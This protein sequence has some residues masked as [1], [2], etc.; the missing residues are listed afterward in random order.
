MNQPVKKHLALI[1]DTFIPE[2]NG[3]A[4]TLGRLHSHFESMGWKVSVIRPRAVGEKRAPGLVEG[5]PIPM[6]PKLK[7]GIASPLRLYHH[8][9]NTKPDI[10]HIATEGPL[11]ILCLLAGKILKIPVVSS[12]HTNF[13]AYASHY[14]LGFFKRAIQRFL[15]WFHNQ[16]ERTY[17]PTQSMLASL[18]EIGIQNTEIWS[19]GVDSA[20]FTPECQGESIRHQLQLSRSDMLFLYVG[21]LAPEKN[22]QL[23]LNAFQHT[24]ARLAQS[25]I[26][27]KLALVGDGP[28]RQQL[29]D[30]QIPG[31]VIPGEFKG[32]LLAR[33]YA[34]ANVFVFASLTETFG[35]V[36]LEAQASGLP[37]VAIRCPILK[38]RILDQEDGLLFH[39]QNELQDLMY[40]LGMEKNL[41]TRIG[42]KAR[43]T[44]KKQS[45]ENV[46]SQLEASYLKVLSPEKGTPV[47]SG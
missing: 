12:Y 5:F 14:E 32:T 8:I 4:L 28:L 34:S 33:W 47:I 6:Y 24:R 19:R 18:N 39:S 36:I 38:E 1:T 11:G 22:I 15:V 23:L 44:A 3:V 9:L 41:R 37:V 21:R 10:L 43:E 26:Q 25:G 7:F 16:T 45:W 2:V 40:L 31:L 35:N 42:A 20:H 46:F 27:C 17:V 29:Q 30:M 13:D